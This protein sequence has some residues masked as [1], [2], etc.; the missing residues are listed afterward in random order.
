MW[1]KNDG[2]GVL[3]GAGARLLKAAVAAYVEH[4]REHDCWD[5]PRP[6]SDTDGV[7]ECWLS[8][9]QVQRMEHGQR[10]H[11]IATV[12]RALLDRA[13]QAPELT[14]DSEATVYQI[15]QFIL[16]AM[17]TESDMLDDMEDSSPDSRRILMSTKL[18]VA[19]AA[20]ELCPDGC[21]ECEWCAPDMGAGTDAWRRAV[22]A[23]ADTVLWDRDWEMEGLF[24]DA[25]PATG[26]AVKALAGIEEGYFT[27]PAEE[28]SP[29]QIAVAKAYLESIADGVR[30]EEASAGRV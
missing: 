14:A 28:P 6:S 26:A 21:G 11:M 19:A 10:L 8:V 5:D 3:E 30:A 7:R 16:R 1:H 18:A 23:V 20:R 12:T 9:V 29:P 13:V 17:E 4:L 27:T 22:E 24:G 15:Y 25:N 2:D